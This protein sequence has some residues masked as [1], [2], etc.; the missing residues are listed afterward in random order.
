MTQVKDIVL[1]GVGAIGSVLSARLADKFEI[2]AIG[3]GGEV[4]LIARHGL[5]IEG[6]M[7]DTVS[8]KIQKKIPRIIR[9][10]IIFMCTKANNID[11][12]VGKITWNDPSLVTLVF[13]QNGIGVENKTASNYKF[14]I[15]RVVTYLSAQMI[16]L[17]RVKFVGDNKTC[18][19]RKDD[20]VGLM[21]R[22]AGFK[23][24]V[25]D[26]IN[27]KVWEK[28]VYNCVINGLG[29]ILEVRNN[30]LKGKELSRI[31]DMII[32]ECVQVAEAEN[33]KIE[34]DILDKIDDF[35]LGS[36]NY[37]ST[38]VDLKKRRD[39]E[40]EYLNGAIVSRGEVHGIATPA[41]QFV[42]DLIKFKSKI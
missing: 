2:L 35:I 3:N 39:T 20:D 22:Q 40:I 36:N 8:I 16:S 6:E 27:T 30:A 7:N 11:E 17:N 37:N 26:D 24:E 34:A 13:M 19:A 9:P 23:T 15:V 10:T 14:R 31:K 18:F 29:T 41:N 42:Y 25:V 21:L 38:L 1:I 32:R 33:V 12:I 28:L 4:S 5:K